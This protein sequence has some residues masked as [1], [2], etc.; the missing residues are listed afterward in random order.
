MKGTADTRD[1]RSHNILSRRTRTSTAG[2]EAAGR[3][4][5]EHATASRSSIT[6][7][8]RGGAGRSKA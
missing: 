3:V 7:S 1:T 4:A 5:T 8:K 6:G 2:A